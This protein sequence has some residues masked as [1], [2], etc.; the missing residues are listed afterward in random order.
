[1]P[2]SNICTRA[3]EYS[4]SQPLEKIEIP[5]PTKPACRLH[6]IV[7]RRQLPDSIADITADDISNLRS[8][9]DIAAYTVAVASGVQN[10]KNCAF[11]FAGSLAQ[12]KNA[13]GRSKGLPATM[14]SLF[15]RFRPYL[16]GD[17]ILWALNEMCNTDKH[18]ML[19]PIRRCPSADRVAE[20]LCIFKFH[21]FI[22]DSSRS[23]KLSISRGFHAFFEL[24]T[25]GRCR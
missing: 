17:G 22:H 5:H 18:K 24:Q 6:K 20:I 23:K 19:R 15:V 13:L 25:S 8:A 3:R 21:R 2:A 14:Q 11:L 12:M 1:M 9:L 4:E 16:G 7:L 10:P